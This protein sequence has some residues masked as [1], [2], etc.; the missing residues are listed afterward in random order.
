MA[1]KKT[2]TMSK[3]RSWLYAVAQLLGDYQVVRKGRVAQRLARRAAG[4]GMG[5]ILG[6]LFK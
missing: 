3:T 4:K 6:K 1:K 2:M 5:R